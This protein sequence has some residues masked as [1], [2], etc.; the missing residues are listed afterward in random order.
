MLRLQG[1]LVLQFGDFQN[2]SERVPG[3]RHN[4]ERMQMSRGCA[5]GLVQRVKSADNPGLCFV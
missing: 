4:P 3:C 2:A 5:W 1:T